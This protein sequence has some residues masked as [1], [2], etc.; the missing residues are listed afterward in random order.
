MGVGIVKRIAVATI[1]PKSFGG[2][3]G[4]MA[5]E[6]ACHLA[7]RYEVLLLCPG[8]RTEL[9]ERNSG[10]T[11][12]T[13]ASAGPDE[14]YY[15]FLDR[16]TASRVFGFLDGFQPDVIHSHDPIMLGALAQ[17]WALTRSVPFVL[18]PHC[19]PDRYLEFGAGDRSVLRA[20]QLVQPIVRSYLSRFLGDCDGIIVNN[21]S[22]SQSLRRYELRARL[23]P[24]SNGRDLECFRSFPNADLTEKDRILCFI[25]FLSDRKN[26]LYLLQ[27][28]EHLPANYRLQLVGKALVRDYERKLRGYAA[29]RDLSNVQFLGELDYSAIPACLARAH[30][31]VSASKLEVQCLTIIEALAS[32]TPVIGLANETL[33]ELVDDT[34]GRRLPKET[35][36]AEFARWVG[37][38]CSLSQPEYDVMCRRARARVEQMDWASVADSHATAY[39]TLANGHT[40]RDPSPAALSEPD[41]RRPGR[42]MPGKLGLPALTHSYAYLNMRISAF[43][44]LCHRRGR[45]P[46]TGT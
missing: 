5:H 12:L 34:V 33:D 16:R 14:V 7:E 26:Q 19:L 8:Q 21:E 9:A 31:F 42:R 41:R 4:M 43:F 30:V 20:R 27:M 28:L 37:R 38:I 3:A 18:T 13:V 44:Y 23:F 29:K 10:L 25:G 1:F 2:G 45:R 24:I 22:V 11:V 15:P 32:G 46:P 35:P 39:Q 40:S 17:Y 6:L 36:P